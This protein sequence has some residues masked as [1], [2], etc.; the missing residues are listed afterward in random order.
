VDTNKI[1][2]ED[3]PYLVYK[4]SEQVGHQVRT[5]L[6]K[7]WG[8]EF[9]NTGIWNYVRYVMLAEVVLEKEALP[10]D[11][12]DQAAVFYSW[13]E[14][15]GFNRYD[16][17][18]LPEFIEEPP[19]EPVLVGR[20]MEQELPTEVPAH[21]VPPQTATEVLPRMAKKK[22]GA[23]DVSFKDPHLPIGVQRRSCDAANPKTYET[24]GMAVQ[25]GD[26]CTCYTYA[27][28]FNLKTTLYLDKMMAWLK[29]PS[30][31]FMYGQMKYWSVAI[32]KMAM[33]VYCGR[34]H[35]TCEYKVHFSKKAKLLQ[36]SWF[37]HQPKSWFTTE[38]MVIAAV[39]FMTVFG[40]C[41]LSSTRLQD[42][43]GLKKNDVL[44]FKAMDKM[45][46]EHAV[47]S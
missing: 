12:K 7:K 37:G 23:I 20:S 24:C 26:D 32:D 39:L 10:T 44:S 17:R 28:P 6:S 47:R 22:A 14:S 29:L 43:L 13:F 5:Y 38:G 2:W 36:W 30:R 42:M 45:V 19:T 25:D 31:A 16:G 35:K 4:R 3:L 1:T 9:V 40:P 46:I 41:V 15:V 33:D 11:W 34:G 8:V 27:V 18:F 21:R